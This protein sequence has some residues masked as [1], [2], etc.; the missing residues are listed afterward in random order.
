[1]WFKNLRAFRL[2]PTWSMDAE[3]LE[4]ALSPQAFSK[5]HENKSEMQRLGWVPVRADSGLVYAR[6]GQYLITLRSE[7]KLLPASV[8]N[9]FA[10]DKAQALEEQQGYKPGR[11]QIK[12]IKE[13]VTD[14]LLPRAFSLYRDTRVWI[15]T[16]NHWLVVDAGAAAKSDEV[17]GLLAKVIEPFPVAPL[18]VHASPAGCMTSWLIDSEPV[19]HFSVDQDAEL[20]STRSGGGKIRYVRETVAVDDAQK[21]IQDGKQC[22][23]LAMTW[24]DRVSFVLTDGF[25]IK[26]VTPLDV[27]QGEA[28]TAQ[29][30]A[31]QFDADFTL[32]TGELNGLLNALVLALGG[33][34]CEETSPQS[35]GERQAA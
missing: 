9:Q 33:E 1:M 13:Q 16:K 31:E 25:E 5:D 8:I 17:L 18:Y 10:L 32:M 3:A 7:K 26:R 34:R 28:N 15:D 4:Q 2:L 29:N 22:T 6:D 12:E 24:N 21:H 27:L 23:R 35:A 30:E 11:R 14:E 20:A 19:E